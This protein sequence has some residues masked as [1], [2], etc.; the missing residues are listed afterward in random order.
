MRRLLILTLLMLP[1]LAEALPAP[2]R[3][4]S[5]NLCT[6]EYLLALAAPEQ[7][8]SI[9]HLG[10]NRHENRWYEKGHRFGTNAG[11]LESV[12]AQRPDLIVTMAGLSRDRSGLAGSLEARLLALPFPVRVEDVATNIITLARALGRPRAADV[13]LTRLQQLR[14]TAPVR[15]RD[16]THVTSEGL[17]I[18]PDGLGANWLKLA[19]LRQRAANG[20][21]ITSELLLTMSP[22]LLVHSRYRPGQM[23]RSQQW[24][25]LRIV[26]GRPGWQVIETDGRPW[27]CGGPP[28]IEE[29]L[30][31]R[32][33]LAS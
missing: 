11:T 12:A 26:R 33:E 28:M 17:T 7:I 8:V 19:G 30:R 2:H 24:P 32:R 13:W 10:H 3:V 5:L 20:N 16:A 14:T 4:V 25:G 27:L 15:L 1:D 22:R 18:A 9:S 6:D 21:R 29:I 31:L 23:A